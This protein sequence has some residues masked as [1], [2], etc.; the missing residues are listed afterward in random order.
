MDL[1]VRRRFIQAVSGTLIASFA[2]CL[3]E[4]DGD[5]TGEED[6]HD[7]DDHD[8]DHNHDDHEH[9][10]NHG[11]DHEL[12]HPESEI[13]VEMVTDENGEHFIPHVVHIEEGGTIEWVLESGSH[14]TVAY[15]PDTHG[16]QQRIPDEGDP[17][18]SDEGETFE[19]TFDVE[20]VYDYVCTPHEEA[21]M[22]GSIIVGWPD[23]DDQP[24]LESPSDDLPDA[25]IEQLE[26]YNEQVREALEDDEGHDHDH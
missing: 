22:I 14:D 21:G 25:A 4:D 10:H 6:D 12:G 24:G 2:G 3:S 1:P 8:D 7:H 26:R 23:P 19:R 18:E 11:H 15:H 9:T 20:G 16:D 13:E 17:W 5:K